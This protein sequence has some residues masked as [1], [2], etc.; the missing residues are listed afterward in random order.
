M[1]EHRP[2]LFQPRTLNKVAVLLVEDW[3]LLNPASASQHP[4]AQE[5]HGAALSSQQKLGE[6]GS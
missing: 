2:M 1:V 6:Y 5:Q 3:S 4:A